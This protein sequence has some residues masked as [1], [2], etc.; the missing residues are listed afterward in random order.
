[1]VKDWDII[2]IYLKKMNFNLTKLLEVIN[3]KF[4]H[5]KEGAVEFLLTEHQDIVAKLDNV[6]YYFTYQKL[7]EVLYGNDFDQFFKE[8]TQQLINDLLSKHIINQLRAS[9]G[10]KTYPEVK[11]L[12]SDLNQHD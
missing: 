7:Q 8:D 1:M 12:P 6:T 10:R 11:T 4:S 9:L 2:Y 3:T 5:P